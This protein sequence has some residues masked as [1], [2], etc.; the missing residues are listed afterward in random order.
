[1]IDLQLSLPLVFRKW[2]FFC[3]G[4]LR[5]E[6]EKHY[7]KKEHKNGK[8]LF[9]S[10]SVTEGHP[11]KVCDA[12]SDAILDACMAEDPMSRVACET[13]SCTGFVLVTGEITTKAQLDIP[14]IVRKTVNEIGYNDAKT[15]FDGNTCAVMVALDQQSPD[16]AMGVDKALEAKEG[17]LNR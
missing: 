4:E 11:D 9:T 5:K 8:R 14:A 6:H 15:G 2:I 3:N 17:C 12:I 10:E 1:M 13:A 7:Q 16:I